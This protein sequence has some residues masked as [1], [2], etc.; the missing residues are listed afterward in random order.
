[1]YIAVEDISGENE[2]STTRLLFLEVNAYRNISVS[3]T[4]IYNCTCSIDLSIYM[5]IL[6]IYIHTFVSLYTACIEKVIYS[7]R[8]L[9]IK[10]LVYE[11]RNRPISL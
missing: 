1:M 3:F 6:Y 8:A 11:L 7:D 9:G 4:Y 2:L 5:Y 10:R